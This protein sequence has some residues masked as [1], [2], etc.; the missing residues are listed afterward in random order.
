[1]QQDYQPFIFHERYLG[2]G[3]MIQ[4]EIDIIEH[5]ENEF[6]MDMTSSSNPMEVELKSYRYL[7]G[8]RNPLFEPFHQIGD[9][10]PK[11]F[12]D[13]NNHDKRSNELVE[14][15]VEEFDEGN[16][17]EIFSPSLCSKSLDDNVLYK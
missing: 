13:K 7:E 5:I 17:Y 9:P 8:Q 3:S 11:N 1:M 6:C 2:E 15:H 12:Y 16:S 10:I 4:K 14:D